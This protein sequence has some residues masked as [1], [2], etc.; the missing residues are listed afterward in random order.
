MYPTYT[1]ADVNLGEF[2]LALINHLPDAI[3]RPLDFLVFS[4]SPLSVLIARHVL[5]IQHMIPFLTIGI[6]MGCGITAARRIIQHRPWN[7]AVTGQYLLLLT[8]IIAVALVAVILWVLN[9]A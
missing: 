1:W 7:S 4:G 2:A 8:M 3:E 6:L 5:P 9:L